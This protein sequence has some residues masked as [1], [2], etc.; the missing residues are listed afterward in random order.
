MPPYDAKTAAMETAD[1]AVRAA[2][3]GAC[4][5]MRARVRIRAL[6]QRHAPPPPAR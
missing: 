1:R 4:L 5:R 6:S 2:R 3:R